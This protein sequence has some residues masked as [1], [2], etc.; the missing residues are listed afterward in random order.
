ME[1]RS[2]HIEKVTRKWVKEAG[3][4]QPPI[5]FV[6]TV[7]MAIEAKAVPKKV[8]PPLISLRGWSVVFIVLLATIV[9]ILLY[10][11][12]GF[13]YLEQLNLPNLREIKNPF[14]ALQMSKALIY[15]VGFLTLFLIQ[16]PFLKRRFIH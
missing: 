4:E 10:P 2:E 16:I 9:F 13:S 15:G 6:A 5:N 14:A 12:A 3:M 8:Y 11:V 1:E 7:M